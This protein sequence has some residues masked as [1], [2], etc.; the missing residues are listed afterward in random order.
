MRRLTITAAALAALGIG[1]CDRLILGPDHAANTPPT[2]HAT[3]FATILDSMRYA[4]DMPALAAAIVTDDSTLELA[5]VGSRRWGGPANVTVADQ[6]HLG[7]DTKAFTATLIGVLVDEGRLSWTTTLPEIF[8]ELATTMRPEYRDVTVR[9]ILS[10][11][12]GLL[13]DASP[14]FTRGTPR[15]Q[16][17][18]LVAWA[19]RQPPIGPRGQYSYSNVGYSVAG[20]IAER[21]ADGQYEDLLMAK[22]LQP[23]GITSAG[24]GPMG[25]PGLEDEPLQHTNSHAPVEP[26]PDADNP[27]IYAPAGRLHMAVGDWAR[28]ARWILA[29]EAGH[30]TFLRPETARMLTDSAVPVPGVGAYALGWLVLQRAW[31]GGRSLQHNGSNELNYA[32]IALAPVLRCG[33]LVATNQGPGVLDN[34]TD[35]VVARLIG[36]YQ[37]GQ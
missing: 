28:F 24:F 15:D 13:R 30:Q 14:T 8:P 16:R 18:D 17:A 25:T 4:L 20:A 35:P 29:S 22:V 10:H 23:L 33:I 12:A 1:A 5:A 21:L 31:A 36:Y 32:E 2:V 7:S 34:P 6:F 11:S 26:T 19:L 27:P 9:E 3:R 37:T